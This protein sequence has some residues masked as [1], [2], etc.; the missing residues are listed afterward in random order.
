VLFWLAM[1]TVFLTAFY[2]FRAIFMTFHGSYR[3][4]DESGKY[5]HT[6]ESPWV[7][8]GP[9]VFLAVMAVV[10]GWWNVTGAFSEFMGHGG[11][12]A[13]QS[14]PG[15][16]FG[17][18]THTVN[19][20]PLPLISL[21]VAL[22]GIFVA[23][24]IYIRRWITAESVG[25]AFGSL[26]TLVFRKYYF[27][28]LYENIIVKIALIKGLFSGFQLFDSKGVDGAVNGVADG[29][30]SG[31]RAIRHAQTGQLQ[32]YAL[33]IGIGVVIITLCVYFFG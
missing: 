30:I 33:F 2:M 4:G 3:G 9:L 11:E 23:Y 10:A 13:T 26:Y 19:G 16:F 12:G 24:A 32:L 27:D 8:V 21:V 15:A 29:V 31:G 28:E 14:F 25:R 22:F 18:F 20:I 17:V 7:M 1:I 5:H 6:H